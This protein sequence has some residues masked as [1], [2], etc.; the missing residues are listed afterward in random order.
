MVPHI[1]QIPGSKRQGKRVIRKFIPST[2]TT[3]IAPFLGAGWVE[4]DCAEA[5]M[6]V[7]GSDANELQINLWDQVLRNPNIVADLIERYAPFVRNK[8]VYVALA[9]VVGSV[10]SPEVRAATYQIVSHLSYAAMGANGPYSKTKHAAYVNGFKRYVEAVREFRCLNLSVEWCDYRDALSRRPGV[11][12]YLDPPYDSISSDRW[13]GWFDHEAL[14]D[15]LTKRDAPW[16]CSYGA[17]PR[18]LDLYRDFTIVDLSGMWT[19]PIRKQK[20]DEILILS[21]DIPL[22]E[23]S[24]T[25]IGG[26]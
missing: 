23:G 26:R 13:Y 6:R 10:T 5:G 8:N 3:L 9:G 17:T 2:W 4:R 7:F 15:V 1:F 24:W 12:A 19:H 20:G 16:I 18:I 21:H 14:C 25:L 22:P 11:P